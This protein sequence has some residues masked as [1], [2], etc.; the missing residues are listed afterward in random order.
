MPQS[1]QL[2]RV[3]RWPGAGRLR[4]E[5]ETPRV[6]VLIDS[7]LRLDPESAEWTVAVRYDVGG[8]PLS[9]INLK[10]PA[11]WARQAS[12]QLPGTTFQRLSETK[13]DV[14]YWSIR[15]DRPAWGSQRLLIRSRLPFAAGDSRAFPDV[16]PL[17]RG[18]VDT[19]L[20][21]INATKLTVAPGGTPGLQPTAPSAAPS[22]ESDW[23]D[24]LPALTTN[25]YHVVREGWSLRV[26][27]PGSTPEGPGVVG[28]K[29]LDARL[30]CT[31]D[32]EGRVTGTAR[33]HVAARTGPFLEI[34]MPGHRPP[35]WASVNGIPS[36]PLRSGTGRWQF[37]LA[38]EG[39]SRVVIVW[40]VPGKAADQPGSRTI[41]LPRLRQGLTPVSTV[42]TVHAPAGV[43]L[44]SQTP[45]LRPAELERAFLHEAAWI[46]SE[47]TDALGRFDRSSR[48]D[49]EDLVAD[50]MRFYVSIRQ[51]ERAASYDLGVPLKKRTERLNL[52]RQTSNRLR[53][54][55]LDSLYNAGLEDDDRSAR[56]WMGLE[57]D[58]KEGGVAPS[59]YPAPPLRLR[60]IGTPHAFIGELNEGIAPSIQ[61]TAD[62]AASTDPGLTSWL[63]ALAG[64]VAGASL[65]ALLGRWIAASRVAA[66]AG[67]LVS[68]AL[69]AVGGGAL[70]LAWATGLTVAGR[71]TGRA[72]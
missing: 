28:P 20:R 27:R 22:D 23:V 69:A 71:L 60:F 58:A 45:Q 34:Q 13:G 37:A 63:R 1:L 55:L 46:K 72:A 5:V 70:G 50:L 2:F 57:S 65:G 68:L 6:N 14:T 35:L 40:R 4:R 11:D 36:T 66:R 3:T 25:C 7:R 9:V 48:K 39:D 15:P 17:G 62:P 43:S 47:T 49:G 19:Y 33:F 10:L 8:G 64:T 44:S 54:E 29:V 21:I 53:G 31:V 56:F 26:S 41:I 18:G 52:V 30:S 32:S 59:S 24:L 42:V 67:L 38:D 61:W 12:V 16:S 51:A